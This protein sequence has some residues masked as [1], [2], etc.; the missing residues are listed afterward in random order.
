MGMSFVRSLRRW[1]GAVLSQSHLH[2]QFCGSRWHSHLRRLLRRTGLQPKVRKPTIVMCV[3]FKTVTSHIKNGHIPPP[4]S[5]N[6]TTS[7]KHFQKRCLQETWRKS[8]L[9]LK[10]GAHLG[11]KLGNRKS[12]EPWIPSSFSTLEHHILAH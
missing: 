10:S 12:G 4:N 11:Y 6:F 1:S 8:A 2:L 5:I 3:E 9:L 7:M